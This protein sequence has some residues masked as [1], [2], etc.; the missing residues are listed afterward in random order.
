MYTNAKLADLYLEQY[1]LELSEDYCMLT[2][3]YAEIV[4]DPRYTADACN[5]FA[6]NNLKSHKIDEPLNNFNAELNFKL[7][8]NLLSNINYLMANIVYVIKNFP[9]RIRSMRSIVKYLRHI[10]KEN[11]RKAVRSCLPPFMNYWDR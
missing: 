9:I 6:I 3:K 2:F 8:H 4:N 10:R 11:L 5:E 7:E 1:D